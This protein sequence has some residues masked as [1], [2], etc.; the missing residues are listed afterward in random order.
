MH[1]LLLHGKRSNEQQLLLNQLGGTRT[2]TGD[3]KLCRETYFGARPQGVTGHELPMNAFR[4]RDHRQ[5][6]RSDHR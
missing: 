3:L 2:V 1:I 5:T 4:T 6:L